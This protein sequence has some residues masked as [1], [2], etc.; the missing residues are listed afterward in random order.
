MLCDVP[1]PALSGL[2]SLE[3]DGAICFS[4]LRDDTAGGSSSDRT[5]RQRSRLTHR[6]QKNHSA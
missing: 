3:A 6:Y 1:E 5:K 4:Q 2:A